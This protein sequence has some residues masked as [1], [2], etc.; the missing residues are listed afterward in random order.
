MSTVHRGPRASP[1][2]FITLRGHGIDDRGILKLS[3]CSHARRGAAL[4]GGMPVL[5]VH[6]R[7]PADEDGNARSRD[8]ASAN[9]V[10][11]AL[12]LAHCP[13]ECGAFGVEKF[14]A[15]SGDRP[16]AD[17]TSRAGCRLG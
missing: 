3:H 15:S 17:V 2:R 9:G 1:E 6:C 5:L 4:T 11:P 13:D 16:Q 12:A 10:V 14:C 7:A 8:A